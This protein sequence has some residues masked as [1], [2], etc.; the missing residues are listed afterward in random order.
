MKQRNLYETP[1]VEV[2]D[3]VGESI[4]TNSNEKSSI[5]Y[6]LYGDEEEI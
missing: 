3:I 2:I 1:S 4:C 5:S 6:P